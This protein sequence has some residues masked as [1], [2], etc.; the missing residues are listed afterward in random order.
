MMNSSL[1]SNFFDVVLS[2]RLEKRKNMWSDMLE[3]TL[4][5]IL[6]GWDY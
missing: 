2:C 5:Y 4:C 1:T 6:L 3:L